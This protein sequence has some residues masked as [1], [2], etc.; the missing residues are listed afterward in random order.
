HQ[1]AVDHFDAL[2]FIRSLATSGD[3]IGENTIKDIHRLVVAGTL[4]DEAGLY[5]KHP[6]RIVG[7]RV[8]FP[9][10]FQVPNLMKEFGDGLS[11]QPPT[12]ETAFQAHLQLVSIHPFSDGN[13][14]TAR[15]LMNLVLMRGG[16]PQVLISP[17][18]RP[19]YLDAI[20]TVQLT[21][22]ETAYRA[23]MERQLTSSLERHLDHISGH[24]KTN[25]GM[26]PR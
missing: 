13:G 16:Y 21:G 15:L 14:R 17:A 4:R 19:D 11:Q 9:N 12:Y 1:E 24:P 22:D 23:F 18:D 3:P 2:Q 20:E 8:E 10:P 6:R 26:K 5:S 7:S 25:Q